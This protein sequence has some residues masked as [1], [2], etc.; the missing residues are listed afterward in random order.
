[1]D[2]DNPQI[3]FEQASSNNWKTHITTLEAHIVEESWPKIPSSLE[4]IPPIKQ[5]LESAGRSRYLS[6]DDGQFSIYGYPDLL[7]DSAKVLAVR[8]IGGLPEIVA[9]HRFPSFVAFGIGAS[10]PKSFQK[11][12]LAMKDVFQ[13]KKITSLHWISQK[14]RLLELKGE[15]YYFLATTKFLDINKGRNIR[16][17]RSKNSVQSHKLYPHC[18]LQW[19]QQ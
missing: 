19:S 18:F 8:H 1:M 13:K 16:L 15:I 14:I 7:R 2:K 9:L 12:R 4:G 10:S 5:I 6:F 17:V 3:T 11:Y